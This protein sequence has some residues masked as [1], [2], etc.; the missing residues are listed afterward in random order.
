MSFKWKTILGIAAIELVF[1]SFLVW[2]AARFIQ[3]LGETNIEK[4]ALNTV[5]LANN[6]LLDSLI[7]YDLATVDEQVQQLGALNGVSYVTLEQHGKRLSSSG[8]YPSPRA[9]S[10]GLSE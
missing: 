5:M 7:A 4:R 3:D 8:K 2:Q 9:H 6:V 1:L 10:G